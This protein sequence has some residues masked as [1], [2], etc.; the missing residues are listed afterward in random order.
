M[1]RPKKYNTEEERKAAQREAIKR[2]KEEHPD[3]QRNWLKAHP[4]YNKKYYNPDYFREYYQNTKDNKRKDYKETP[5]WRANNLLCAYKQNDRKHERGETTITAPWI[6]EH[7]FSSKC[8]YCGETDWKLLGADRIDNTKPH[9]PENVVPCCS[10]C[11]AKKHTTPY[12]EYMRMIGKI[13]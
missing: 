4:H 12:D 6:L 11:N 13:A 9:T 8:V 7:I 2:W 1:G 5:M 10:Y 3:Y